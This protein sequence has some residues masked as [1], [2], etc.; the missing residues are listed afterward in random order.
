[1]GRGF[2]AMM[3][4]MAEDER[5]RI[6]KRTHEAD[7]R[8][9]LRSGFEADY[10]SS[11]LNPLMGR[12]ASGGERSPRSAPAR[13]KISSQAVES[14]PSRRKMA[15]PSVGSAGAPASAP[16]T[17]RFLPLPQFKPTHPPRRRGA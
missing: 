4:A 10:R 7:S 2:M 1:M 6:I 11:L 16:A 15:P 12:P 9:G 13:R 3:S 14:K 17:D 8:S 5:L